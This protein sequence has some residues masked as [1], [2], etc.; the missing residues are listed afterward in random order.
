VAQVIHIRP[1]I[2][3]PWHNVQ[4]FGPVRFAQSVV[5]SV[6][7]INVRPIPMQ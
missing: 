7:N 4:D 3:Q 2:E 6:T 5:K 1:V